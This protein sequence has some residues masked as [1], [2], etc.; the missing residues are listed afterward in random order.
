MEQQAI[1]CPSCEGSGQVFAHV[2]SRSP[3]YSGY[4]W[5]PCFTCK[6]SGS[7]DA[8][9]PHRKAQG[10]AIAISR[11]QAM[12]SQREQAERLGVSPQLLSRWEHGKEAIPPEMLG[13]IMA[14]E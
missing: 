2:N 11:K 13:K 7:V 9:Y 4:R 1:S 12:R 10:E 5:V 8:G 14:L 6:G 3:G